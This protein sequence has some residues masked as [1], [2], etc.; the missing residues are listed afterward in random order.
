MM[1]RPELRP[2][3]APPTKPPMAAPSP[4]PIFSIT[5]MARSR[6]SS[7]VGL[8]AVKAQMAAIIAPSPTIKVPSAPRPTKAAGPVAPTPARIRQAPDIDR[9]RIDSEAAVSID[10]VTPRPSMTP[11]MTARPAT[12]AVMMPIEA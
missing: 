11:R 1:G 6:S 4:V 3:M 5:I 2:P 7:T 9:S 10:A 12:T 8:S